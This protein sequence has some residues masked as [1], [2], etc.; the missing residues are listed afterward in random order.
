[1]NTQD[2]SIDQIEA[3]ARE[4]RPG[5][6][7]D[8]DMA[9]VG[10]SLGE[11][12]RLHEHVQER[13]ADESLSDEDSIDALLFAGRL[14]RAIDFCNEPPYIDPDAHV[15]QA[16]AEVDTDALIDDYYAAREVE[17]Q[18]ETDATAEAALNTNPDSERASFTHADKNLWAI[19]TGDDEYVIRTDDER[20]REEHPDADTAGKGRRDDLADQAVA[21]ATRA[22]AELRTQRETYERSADEA[23]HHE[24]SQRTDADR[25]AGYDRPCRELD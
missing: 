22:V 11:V 2:R 16:L 18:K 24:L 12:E 14:Q 6:I 1:M 21:D 10:L 20:R 17:G 4:L 23:R 13:A 5:D 19:R 7:T 9:R 8:S 25:T 3:L 15:W